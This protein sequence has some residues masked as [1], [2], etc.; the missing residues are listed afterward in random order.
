MFPH[1]SMKASNPKKRTN[2][3]SDKNVF[4]FWK[5]IVWWPKWGERAIKTEKRWRGVYFAQTFERLAKK[6][7][8][9]FN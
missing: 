1:P 2:E 5:L 4:F 7:N 6:K 8:L 3:K 9:S